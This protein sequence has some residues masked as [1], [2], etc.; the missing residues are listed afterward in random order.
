APSTPA[1]P[2]APAGGPAFMQPWM[3]LVA[4]A[5]ISFLVSLITAM[6]VAKS[7]ARSAA[8]SAQ[9]MGYA[10]PAYPAP[11]WGAAAPSQP[12]AQAPISA[13]QPSPPPAEDLSDIDI[14]LR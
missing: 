7:V 5:L 8:L 13:P 11:G 6:A 14:E 12:P 3:W 4:A 9:P 2:P 1:A 10:P